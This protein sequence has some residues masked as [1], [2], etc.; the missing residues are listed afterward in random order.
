[1]MR[2]L[3][4]SRLIWISTVCK[5][6]SEFIW[7]PKL[8]DLTLILEKKIQRT[9]PKWH[10]LSINTTFQHA[11]VF[12]KCNIHR[13]LHPRVDRWRSVIFPIWLKVFNKLELLYTYHWYDFRTICFL[14]IWY[15]KPDQR[16]EVF[17]IH[18]TIL[19]NEV[20]VGYLLLRRCFVK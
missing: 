8:P 18:I 20:N 13:L 1:M 14:A 17:W 4:R 5:C 9:T 6:I 3:I 15:R 12:I 7:C 19:Y 11:L 16:T 10:N 2:R